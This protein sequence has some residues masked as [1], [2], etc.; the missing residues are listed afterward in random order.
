MVAF[1]ATQEDK[2]EDELAE[3]EIALI[4]R[5]VMESFRRSR[6]N[7]RG[8]NFGKGKYIT[9]QPR[10]DGKCYECEKYGHI[11]SECPEAKKTHSRGNQK[12]KAL[13]S[14]SD[15]HNSENEHEEISNLCFMAM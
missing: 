7:I 13:S 14:W 2:G 3:D 4:T 8:R 15:E 10:N 5:S 9:D 12:N 11:A 1:K 6:N